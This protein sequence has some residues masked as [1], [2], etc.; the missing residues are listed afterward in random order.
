MT[1]LPF[2]DGEQF[3]ETFEK[4][5]QERDVDFISGN[6]PKLRQ[7]IE[8]HKDRTSELAQLESRAKRIVDHPEMSADGF[9]TRVDAVNETVVTGPFAMIDALGFSNA[10]KTEALDVVSSKYRITLLHS[11]S[12]ASSPVLQPELRFLSGSDTVFLYFLADNSSV[13]DRL[14]VLVE[15]I[16]VT[17]ANAIWLQGLAYEKGA[18]GLS[19]FPL[20]GAITFGEYCVG[21]FQFSHSVGD[22][23]N[24]PIVLGQPVVNAQAWEQEQKWFGASIHPESTVRIDSKC[25]GLLESLAEQGFLVKWDVP[26]EH[27]P[28]E[29]WAINF[30]FRREESDI[31]AFMNKT[32]LRNEQETTELRAKAKHLAARR[33]LEHITEHGIYNPT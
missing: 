28:I 14:K 8:W 29:A 6:L 16:A 3:I 30:L 9:S 24:I 5:V 26:T 22:S 2:Q 33:F 18:K 20:R 13:E 10:L 27:G 11:C 1:K 7:L 17:L 12:V 4:A 32:L 15:Y 19:S 31:A 25:P 23:V 21:D